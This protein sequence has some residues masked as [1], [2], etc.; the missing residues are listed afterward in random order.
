MLFSERYGYD[1][2][3]VK[4]L[5]ED[6][7]EEIR[8]RIW[9][10]FYKYYFIEKDGVIIG[11]I[12]DFITFIWDKFFK[13]DLS[14]LISSRTFPISIY[15]NP[16]VPKIKKEFMT[17][18]W[19]KVYNFIE[20]FME[21]IPDE[22]KDSEK[23]IINEINQILEEEKVPYRIV[24]DK[25][26]PLTSKEEIEEVENALNQQ[27]QF[28]PIKYHLKKAL[29][30]FSDRRKPDYAN[31]IKESISTVGA[32]VQIIQGEKGTL[33]ELIKNL[34]IHPALKKGF[35]NLY[36]WTSDDGGIRHPI[37]GNQLEPELAEARY[38]LI[39]ASAFVNYVI[40]KYREG[41]NEEKK[42]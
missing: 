25:V 4:R 31:S 21:N 2:T 38:M 3:D 24:S 16:V 6:V 9:N 32:L 22:A 17:I 41:E 8:V 27:G 14:K 33:G 34:N 12:P 36:G 20:F 37:Y 1:K 28:A 11:A 30:K 18:P 39:T 26:T 29:D 42:T 7:P 19:Y 10:V 13:K 23:I 5:Y 40:S 15:N 35:S